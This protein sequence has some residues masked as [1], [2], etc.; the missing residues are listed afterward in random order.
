[1][2]GHSWVLVERSVSFYRYIIIEQ[3]VD[4]ESKRCLLESADV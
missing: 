1:M 3:P 2:P 4:V